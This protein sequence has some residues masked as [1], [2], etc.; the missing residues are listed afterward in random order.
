MMKTIKR[1]FNEL[2]IVFLCKVNESRHTHHVLR[3]NFRQFTIRNAIMYSLC[4]DKI[5]Y[6]HNIKHQR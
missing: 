4:T 2:G 5:L 1:E 3:E 6:L